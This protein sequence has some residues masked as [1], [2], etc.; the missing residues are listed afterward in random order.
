[1]EVAEH[2]EHEAVG[3][4]E[5]APV[6]EH[7]VV[8]E[9]E[10][11]RVPAEH[12]VVGSQ[13]ACEVPW[14]WD[15]AVTRCVGGCEMYVCEEHI[16]GACALC[17]LEPLCWVCVEHHHCV[18]LAPG[19]PPAK[20]EVVGEEEVAPVQEHE[21]VDR[22]EVAHV[23]AEHEVVGDEEVAERSEREVV[24]DEE[25]APLPEH[26]VVG[27]EEVAE[28]PEHEVDGDVGASPRTLRKN[29]TGMPCIGNGASSNTQLHPTPAAHPSGAATHILTNALLASGIIDRRKK[30]WDP[31]RLQFRTEACVCDVS[32]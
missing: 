2:P 25:V 7:E 19:G 32:V 23:P 27:D 9:N 30:S 16:S 20:H 5:V 26:E 22:E 24:G 14:C 29:L 12:E 6:R 28:Q 31:K 21:V 15:K 4:K 17:A 11:A 18:P 10:V 13:W 1:M 8:G 3:E